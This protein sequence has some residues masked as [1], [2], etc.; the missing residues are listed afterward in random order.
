MFSVTQLW[1]VA[2]VHILPALLLKDIPGRSETGE[3]KQDIPWATYVL[4]ALI[5]VIVIAYVYAAYRNG[6]PFRIEGA[7]TAR[8]DAAT[9]AVIEG[10]ARAGWNATRLADGRVL[11]TRTTK[12]AVSTTILL[13]L[14]FVLPALIYIVASRKE[15]VAELRV[16][17]PSPHGSEIEI[18]GNMT[19]N[20]GV[21]TAA[22]V[23]R[24]LPKT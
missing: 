6:Q 24:E 3:Q 1:S 5:I 17:S 21:R 7:T 9:D 20:G 14:F 10:Y 4:L 8:P 16:P 13:G 19:G 11:F 15:Q 18:L 22:A 23:L 12:P 2:I